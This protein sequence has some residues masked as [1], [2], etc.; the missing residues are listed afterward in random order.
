M[1]VEGSAKVMSEKGDEILANLSEGDFFGEISLLFDIPCTARVQA[2]AKY[3]FLLISRTLSISIICQITESFHA[4]CP[5]KYINMIVYPK[6]IGI[7][8]SIFSFN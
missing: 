7:P 3:D 1:I 2:D 5:L 4:V 6:A 8:I